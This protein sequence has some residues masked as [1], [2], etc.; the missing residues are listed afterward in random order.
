[1]GRVL[2]AGA[3]PGGLL[4]ALLLGR[5]GHEVLVADP[6]PAHSPRQRRE[7]LQ[8]CGHRALD[9][10]GLADALLGDAAT[11]ATPCSGMRCFR[12]GGRPA[13][14]LDLHQLPLPYNRAWLYRVDALM[15]HLRA[16]LPPDALRLGTA[17]V[18][19]R[20]E[21]PGARVRLSDGSEWAADLVVAADGAGSTVRTLARCPALVHA[22]PGGYFLC[23]AELDEPLPVGEARQYLG[24]RSVG[25][26]PLADGRVY[27]WAHVRVEDDEA[28]WRHAIQGTCPPLDD[29]GWPRWSE[30]FVLRAVQ[31]RCPRWW[32]PGVVLMGDAAHAL[33]PHGALGTNLALEDAVELARFAER[34]GVLDAAVLGPAF[35]RARARK[36]RALQALARQRAWS[37]D[38]SDPFAQGLA[39]RLGRN[40]ARAPGA[41]RRRALAFASGLADGPLALGD[42]LQ[43]LV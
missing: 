42:M 10:A 20:P 8:P 9:G 38:S 39:V 1:M 32:A 14:E 12:A 4:A 2:V 31:V 33:H 11:E 36:V 16:A 22:Y 27:A 5:L 26:V 23:T 41:V 29:A 6:Q 35:Q 37:W 28:T 17:A 30:G 18:Y 3:G 40:A 13:F 43:L 24:R 7:L 19:L 34:L 21:G 25:L 15:G